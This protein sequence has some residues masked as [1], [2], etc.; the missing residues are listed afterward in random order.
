MQREKRHLLP[1]VP[2]N[3]INVRFR[4]KTNKTPKT[5]KLKFLKLLQLHRVKVSIRAISKWVPAQ[6][7]VALKN[8]DLYIKTIQSNF[9]MVLED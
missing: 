7:S 5:K 2:V 9:F 4:K 8:L 3:E 6:G 1:N